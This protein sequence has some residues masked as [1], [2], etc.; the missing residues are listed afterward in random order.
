MGNKV[1]GIYIALIFFVFSFSFLSDDPI[2]RAADESWDRYH[3]L[4]NDSGLCF[5]MIFLIFAGIY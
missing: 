2:C 1:Y 4:Q 5:L 3:T